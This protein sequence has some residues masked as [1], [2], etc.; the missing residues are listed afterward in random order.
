MLSIFSS[1]KLNTASFFCIFITE[2]NRNIFLSRIRETKT[3][4]FG[5]GSG[6][7]KLP[8]IVGCVEAGKSV[9]VDRTTDSNRDTALTL[10]CAGGHT[11]MVRLLLSRGAQIGETK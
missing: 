3:A 5:S 8:S 11:D 6:Q 1:E 7:Y 2:I 4:H 9:D 10:G